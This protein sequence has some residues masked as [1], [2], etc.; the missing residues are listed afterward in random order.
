MRTYLQYKH[1]AGSLEA[2]SWSIKPSEWF[3][4]AFLI[5]ASSIVCH[6]GLRFTIFLIILDPSISIPSI[7][8]E[9]CCS[10]LFG[11][12][13]CETCFSNPSLSIH[14]YSGTLWACYSVWC[15]AAHRVT[16]YSVWCPAHR[17]TCYSVWCSAHRETCYS[18]WCSAHRETCY[19][20]WCSAH[21][22]TC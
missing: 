21:R 15:P 16:W 17:E 6:N 8:R 4:N 18:V 5:E 22:E 19:S 14:C 12:A 3:A 7:L 13:H 1:H 20:V 11:L 2:F 9:S 10:A